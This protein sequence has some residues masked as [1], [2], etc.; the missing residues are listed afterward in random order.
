MIKISFFQKN[1][2]MLLTS[3]LDVL[4]NIFIFMLTTY[5]AGASCLFCRCGK[6]RSVKPSDVTYCT[7]SKSEFESSS[8]RSVLNLRDLL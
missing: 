2:S 7:G 6:W 5:K 8:E 3:K 1:D 4:Y